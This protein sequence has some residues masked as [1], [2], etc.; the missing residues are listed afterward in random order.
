MLVGEGDAVR[1]QNKISISA[2]IAQ[3]LIGKKIG[4]IAEVKAPRGTIKYKVI[5]IS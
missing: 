1:M 2:P 3:A 4:E 5:A